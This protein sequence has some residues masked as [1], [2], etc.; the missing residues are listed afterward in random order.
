MIWLVV[1]GVQ[2]IAIMDTN[3]WAQAMIKVGNQ[4]IGPAYKTRHD[5]M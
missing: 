5:E 1:G 3:Q 4:F 2:R